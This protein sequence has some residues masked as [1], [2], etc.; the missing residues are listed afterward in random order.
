MTENMGLQEA[1]DRYIDNNH[2]LEEDRQLLVCR[3]LELEVQL[4]AGSQ[5]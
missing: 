2:A 3:A 4:E 1:M 5:S